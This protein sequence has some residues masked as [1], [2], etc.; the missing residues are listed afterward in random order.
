MQSTREIHSQNT[1]VKKY[2]QNYTRKYTQ[3]SETGCKVLRRDCMHFDNFYL[4]LKSVEQ[5]MTISCPQTMLWMS[6]ILGNNRM[7]VS[8]TRSVTKLLL[9]WF[10]LVQFN[11]FKP[12]KIS[13]RFFVTQLKLEWFAAVFEMF[14]MFQMFQWHVM[15]SMS[16]F[17]FHFVIKSA[18]ILKK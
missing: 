17:Y 15:Y 9:I 10:N 7:I 8:L 16:A 14:L 13:P 4:W 11:H 3:I 6:V 5:R 18:G 12:L 2:M 1:C